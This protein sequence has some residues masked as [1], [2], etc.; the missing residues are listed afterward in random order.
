MNK[1]VFNPEIVDNLTKE[2][3]DSHVNKV[4]NIC[5]IQESKINKLENNNKATK[6]LN[7]NYHHKLYNSKDPNSILSNKNNL[8]PPK[9]YSNMHINNAKI[10]N[11][12]KR[13]VNINYNLDKEKLNINLNNNNKKNKLNN[14][15]YKQK[16]IKN[17]NS[18]TSN[19]SDSKTETYE[20]DNSTAI[21]DNKILIKWSK[22]INYNTNKLNYSTNK[23]RTKFLISRANNVEIITSNNTNSNKKDNTLKSKSIFENDSILN[24]NLKGNIVSYNIDQGLHPEVKQFTHLNNVED[25]TNSEFYPNKNVFQVEN[26][27]ARNLN[28][29]LEISKNI[30][31]TINNISNIPLDKLL[32]NNPC[33][34]TLSNPELSQYAEKTNDYLYNSNQCTPVNFNVKEFYVNSNNKDNNISNKASLL[35]KQA[36]NSDKSEY[37]KFKSI[38]YDTLNDNN[39]DIGYNDIAEITNNI[40][41]LTMENLILKSKNKELNKAVEKLYQDNSIMYNKME[42]M[43]TDKFKVFYKYLIK[44]MNNYN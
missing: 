18:I 3:I 4:L 8:L 6:V 37:Y 33:V 43:Q 12:D 31:F 38:N 32:L 44:L 27:T 23:K 36:L 19:N 16:L 39:I 22:E 2:S 13:N 40:K 21:N 15:S 10:T 28:N 30:A 24:N 14:N 1:N 26:T 34:K 25:F 5:S 42:K 17:N 29:C 20:L 7:I 9:L 11:K 35:T 41:K